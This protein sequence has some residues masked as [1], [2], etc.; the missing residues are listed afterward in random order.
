MFWTLAWKLEMC[1][2]RRSA[3]NFLSSPYCERCSQEAMRSRRE[4]SVM[5]AR[6]CKRLEMP[7]WVLKSKLISASESV[8]AD[9]IFLRIR[10]GR[11]AS[12]ILLLSESAD[13]LIFFSGFIKSRIRS[14][15]D[16]VLPYMNLTWFSVFSGMV[17]ISPYL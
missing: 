4:V 12:I 3:T 15:K 6:I 8:V 16:W 9:M 17:K 1:S 13:L 2:T 14:A 11:S 5:A 10:S 7:G